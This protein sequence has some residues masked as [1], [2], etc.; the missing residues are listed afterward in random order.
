MSPKLPLVFA[1]HRNGTQTASFCRPQTWMVAQ[2][3]GIPI[4]TAAGWLVHPK[5]ANDIP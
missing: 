4:P 1:V 5:N 2:F 3:P